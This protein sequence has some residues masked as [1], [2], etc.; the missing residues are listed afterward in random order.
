MPFYPDFQK[1]FRDYQPPMLIVW[2]K[3]DKIF[4]EDGFHPYLRDL[5]KAEI[6]ILDSGHFALEDRF[7]RDGLADPRLGIARSPSKTLSTD[8]AATPRVAAARSAARA[9]PH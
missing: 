9:H 4:P 7:E 6:H 1:F 2:G 8:D 3:N 5:P